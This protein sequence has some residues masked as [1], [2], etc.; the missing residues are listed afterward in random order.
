ML[1]FVHWQAYFMTPKLIIY[2][3]TYW[4]TEKGPYY[5]ILPQHNRTYLPVFPPIYWVFTPGKWLH[6][7]ATTVNSLAFN[8]W[9]NLKE[10][11]IVITENWH[12]A[13]Y[14]LLLCETSQ[15]TRTTHKQGLLILYQTFFFSTAPPKNQ[16]D[17]L[18]PFNQAAT[19]FYKKK[20]S[21][22]WPSI[23]CCLTKDLQPISLP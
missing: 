17:L 8:S 11:T 10:L 21:N 15:L 2:W 9:K 3:A 18:V 20:E 5:A 12:G 13:M 22:R 1:R 14:L 16:E 4:S 6:P 19:I 7:P 23:I